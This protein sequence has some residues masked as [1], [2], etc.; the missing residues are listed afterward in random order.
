[1]L[2]NLC[3]QELRTRFNVSMYGY[4]NAPH[5]YIISLSPQLREV[6]ELK[7]LCKLK[8][9]TY[10]GGSRAA[11]LKA[12]SQPPNYIYQLCN[13]VQVTF[14]CLNLL[15]VKMGTTVSVPKQSSQ[16]TLLSIQKAQNI[17]HRYYYV[18]S[19]QPSKSLNT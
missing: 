13:L 2:Q 7:V 16:K 17:N 19:Y 14:L 5:T 12:W 3:Q 8:R 15:L 11:K 1:M 6:N 9:A 18:A 4:T 10:K